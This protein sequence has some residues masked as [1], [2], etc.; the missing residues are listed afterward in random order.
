MKKLL[1]LLAKRFKSKSP[2]GF[3]ILAWSAGVVGTLAFIT[4]A[5]PITLPTFVVGLLPVIETL[6]G[7][8]LTASLFT[9]EDEKIIQETKKALKIRNKQ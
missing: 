9:T 2:K 1:L 3:K 8:V 7:I 5:F 4:P 6:S